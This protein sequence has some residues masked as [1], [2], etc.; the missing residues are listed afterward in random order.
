VCRVSSQRITLADFSAST[1][2]GV[3]SE[4]LRAECDDEELPIDAIVL[5]NVGGLRPA[6]RVENPPYVVQLDM[7]ATGGSR[8][9]RRR[10]RTRAAR[11]GIQATSR[12]LHFRMTRRVLRCEHEDRLERWRIFA[13]RPPRW[14][15]V[16]RARNSSIVTFAIG[17]SGSRPPEAAD[18]SS[19]YGSAQPGAARRRRHRY[20]AARR[21]IVPTLPG[22]GNASRRRR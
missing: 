18:A 2:R 16:G 11:C 14:T 6:R 5:E 4:R 12:A 9:L 17:R 20:A 15:E 3:M 22:Y 19:E 10:S 13:E 1:A 21:T 8:R 7:N